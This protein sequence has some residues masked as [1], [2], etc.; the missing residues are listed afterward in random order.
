MA[1]PAQRPVESAGQKAGESLSHVQRDVDSA[2]KSAQDTAKSVQD[3]ALDTARDTTRKAAEQGS[4]VADQMGRSMESM[5]SELSDSASNGYAIGAAYMRSFTTVGQE[6]S[7]FMTQRVQQN[8][9]TARTLSQCASPFDAWVVMLEAAKTAATDYS[10]EIAC[11]TDVYAAA[12]QDV[13][14][15]A[16]LFG[17]PQSGR[18]QDYARS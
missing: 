7:R 15:G 18:D 14:G 5:T 3:K 12:G 16:G 13:Q 2:A 1:N 17:K 8:L 10:N 11:L 4:R 6:L 9:E